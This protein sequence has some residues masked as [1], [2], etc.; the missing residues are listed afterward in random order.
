MGGRKRKVV[1]T[2]TTTKKGRKKKNEVVDGGGKTS[3]GWLC[4]VCGEVAGRGT[5]T[6]NSCQ[7]PQWV[8]FECGCYTM[9]DVNDAIDNDTDGQLCCNNHKVLKFD[10]ETKNALFKIFVDM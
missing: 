6:C 7:P 5:F 8:H 4:P 2:Q 1:N 10:L 9:G 3:S